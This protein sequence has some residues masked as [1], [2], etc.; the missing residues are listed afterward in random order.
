MTLCSFNVRKI[1]LGLTIDFVISITIIFSSLVNWPAYGCLTNDLANAWLWLPHIN[2]IIHHSPPITGF[3]RSLK[4]HP[5]FVLPVSVRTKS[6]FLAIYWSL[7]S[8]PIKT[9]QVL[10]LNSV[11]VF[12]LIITATK[13]ISY[14]TDRTQWKISLRVANTYI[15][16]H[17]C[18]VFNGHSFTYFNNKQSY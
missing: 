6:F 17:S 9:N 4:G 16:V 1:F 13:L 18:L 10:P 2:F 14:T 5:H 15:V 7:I 11:F 3:T 8:Q 12:D